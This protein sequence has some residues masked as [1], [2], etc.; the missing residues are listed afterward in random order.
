MMEVL[1]LRTQRKVLIQRQGSRKNVIWELPLGFLNVDE[2]HCITKGS[3]V[4][5]IISLTLVVEYK[6]MKM[7][8]CNEL[9]VQL[10]VA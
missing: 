4:K 10:A 7:V 5:H 8:S 6:I 3:I 1:N 9:K 2:M